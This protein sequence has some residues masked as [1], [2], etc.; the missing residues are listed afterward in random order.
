VQSRDAL[1]IR[2]KIII[3]RGIY[4]ILCSLIIHIFSLHILFYAI[5]RLLASEI[6][7]YIVWIILFIFYL[8]SIIVVKLIGAKTKTDLYLRGITVYFSLA[9]LTHIIVAS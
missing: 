4:G 2:L 1:Y 7:I 3:V 5:L 9:I 8:P 6:S